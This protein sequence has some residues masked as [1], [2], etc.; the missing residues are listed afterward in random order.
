[1]ALWLPP[2]GSAICGGEQVKSPGPRTT[3]ASRCPRTRSCRCRAPRPMRREVKSANQPIS[4]SAPS[5]IPNRPN[6]FRKPAS[7]GAMGRAPESSASSAS[8]RRKCAQMC[9]G[10]ARSQCEP[11][12]SA[13][14][15]VASWHRGLA[16]DCAIMWSAF[17]WIL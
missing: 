5:N 1:M 14:E 10:G 4:Q 2:R 12:P 3:A 9:F 17:L 8:P 6:S 11:P 7:Q 15:H 16:L 13:A